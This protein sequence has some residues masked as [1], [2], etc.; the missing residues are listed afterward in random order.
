MYL[1]EYSL[2]V[3]ASKKRLR[4]RYVIYLEVA[5]PLLVL[6]LV[7]TRDTESVETT[8]LFLYTESIPKQE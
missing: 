5:V 7:I 3:L 4:V 2:N 8:V 1:R 6:R